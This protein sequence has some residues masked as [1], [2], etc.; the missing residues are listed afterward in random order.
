M[1][2]GRHTHFLQPVEVII[3]FVQLLPSAASEEIVDVDLLV[4]RPDVCVAGLKPLWE[5]E[6]R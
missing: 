6:T 5:E 1:R 4:L 2:F 3:D